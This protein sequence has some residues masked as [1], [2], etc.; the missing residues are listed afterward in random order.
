MTFWYILYF[1]VHFLHSLRHT[2]VF[3]HKC[4]HQLIVSSITQNGTTLAHGNNGLGQFGQNIALGLMS[5]AARL[6]AQ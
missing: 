5:L 2:L 4:M 6:Y 3:T 1:N